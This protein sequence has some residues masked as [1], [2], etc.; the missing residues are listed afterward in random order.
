MR[1]LP[2]GHAWSLVR[3]AALAAAALALVTLVV[4]GCGALGGALSGALAGPGDK[5]FD[6][7]AVPPFVVI[8][9]G[10]G[11]GGAYRAWVY[12]HVDGAFCIALSSGAGGGSGCGSDL[13]TFGSPGTSVSDRGRYVY[14]GTS[15]PGATSAVMTLADGTTTTS[16]IAAGGAVAPMY[17][18]YVFALPPDARPTVID[19]VDATGATLESFSIGDLAP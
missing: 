7:G 18:F 2:A 4:A 9:Q 19:I 1:R 12:R 13:A 15:A 8:G 16:S 6:E 5:P 14:G 10:N 3:A 17:G 11:P